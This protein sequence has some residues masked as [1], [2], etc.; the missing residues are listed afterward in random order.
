M[1][2]D[3]NRVAVAGRL[4]RLG[5]RIE[6]LLGDRFAAKAYEG[7]RLRLWGRGF[8]LPRVV[9]P[10]LILGRLLPAFVGRAGTDQVHIGADVL[11]VRAGA[12]AGTVGTE[13][14]VL[15]GEF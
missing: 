14:E 5:E 2:A 9:Q 11:A 13:A 15:G 12:V 8:E 4:H 6:L 1:A 3:F 7:A 10:L